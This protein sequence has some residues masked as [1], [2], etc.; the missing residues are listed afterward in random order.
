VR[1]WPPSRADA[2][3]VALPLALATLAAVGYAAGSVF[4]HGRFGSNAYDL[5]LYDQS[6]W[7]FSRFDVAIAHTIAREET[8]IGGHFQPLL[9]LLAPL[10]WIWSDPRMLLGAQAVLLAAAS[11][12]L[13]AWARVRLGTLPATLFQLAFLVFWG[14]VAGNLFDF[15]AVSLAAPIVSATLYA[16]LTRRTRLLLVLVALGLLAREN[17]GLTFAAIG[18]YAAAVQRRVLLGAGIAAVSIAW[19]VVAIK[20]ILPA[21]S[22]R[23]YAHWYYGQLG[24]GPLQAAW[25]LV[26]DPLESARLFFTPHV[27][28]V[29]LV[30]LFAAWLALPLV[31]PL[32][33]VAI[34]SLAER[35]F[36]DRPELWAQGFHYSIVVAPILAFAAIDTT[37]RIVGRVDPSR[38]PLV[39]SA[40]AATVLCAGLYFTFV[41]LRPLDEL[42]RYTSAAHAAEISACLQTIPTDASVSATS[43]LVPH[44]AQRRAIYLLDRRPFVPTEYV[45]IDVVTWMFPLTPRDVD[46]LVDELLGRGYGIICTNPG[47]VVLERGAPRGRLDPALERRLSSAER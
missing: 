3:A 17:L 44:L 9:F 11:V 33:L 26:T 7:G 25:K 20:A 30:N 19:F 42:G 16:L 29:A 32:L 5:G 39:A 24:S 46:R 31:S 28:R 22:G 45:A 15:H 14:V 12:P 13:Y 43:A 34:P 36:A 2:V 21:I 1:N 47:T 18:L 41:R 10:Y 27:K 8:L 38:A 6:I 23:R 4:R 40:I 35:F 37:A